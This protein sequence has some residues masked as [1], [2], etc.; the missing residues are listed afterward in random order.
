[1]SQVQLY[2]FHRGALERQVPFL[3]SGE[4]RGK[5]RRRETGR[6]RNLEKRRQRNARRELPDVFSI[7]NWQL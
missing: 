4:I 5:R 6:R 3:E 7:A 1:M 2:G